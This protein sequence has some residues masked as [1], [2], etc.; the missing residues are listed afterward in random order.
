M[1][2]VRIEVRARMVRVRDMM[3]K[4]EREGERGRARETEG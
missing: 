1:A 4:R 3:G 2:A